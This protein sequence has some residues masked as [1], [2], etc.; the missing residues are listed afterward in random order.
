[1]TSVRLKN[2][3]RSIAKRGNFVPTILKFA[4]LSV[5][6]NSHEY[7]IWR[8]IAKKFNFGDRTVSL[9]RVRFFTLPIIVYTYC[10]LDN[11]RSQK[12]KK[13]KIMLIGF[14]PPLTLR[15]TMIRFNSIAAHM[16]LN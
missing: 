8:E 6:N 12:L 16:I 14:P 15:S 5:Q 4:K 11:N 2:T 13:K 10:L 9:S 1:M 7:Q 3:V